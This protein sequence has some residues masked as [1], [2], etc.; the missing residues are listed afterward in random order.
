MSVTPTSDTFRPLA[1]EVVATTPSTRALPRRSRLPPPW[2]RA[3]SEGRRIVAVGTTS[4]RVLET[5]FGRGGPAEG[6]TRPLITPG[7]RSVPPSAIT[8]STRRGR[9]R[10][11]VM[12]FAGSR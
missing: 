5:V 6:R 2:D 9:P 12:A 7:Y 10:W 4:V 8:N 11:L 3:R 1:E